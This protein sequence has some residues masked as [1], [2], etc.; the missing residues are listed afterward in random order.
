MFFC[1][2]MEKVGLL[3]NTE[4]L[5]YEYLINLNLNPALD[6]N[7]AKGGRAT[8]S[9]QQ[10]T[11]NADNAIDGNYDTNV[12]QGSCSVTRTE[13]NPWWRLDVLKTHQIKTVTVTI[14]EDGFYKS[15]DGAEIRI[16]NSLENNGNINPR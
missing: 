2:E 16:G 11:Y 15:I 3:L 8:Q 5:L 6:T 14:R 13:I 10:G 9:S 4:P 12:K 1:E 7:I